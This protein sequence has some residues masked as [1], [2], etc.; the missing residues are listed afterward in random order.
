MRVKFLVLGFLLLF[1]VRKGY[2]QCNVTVDKTDV[3][4]NGGNNGS[5]S[6]NVAGGASNNCV[7]PPTTTYTCASGCTSTITTNTSDV[8]VGSGQQVCITMT[9]FNKG[10]T[11]NGGTLIIC[12][13]ATPSSVTFNGGTMIVNGTA[14]FNS[15]SVSSS[16]AVLTNYGTIN[17]TSSFSIAGTFNNHGVCNITSGNLND[18][19][20]SG[21][22]NNTN[23]ITI[24]SGDLN[25]NGTF[26][27]SG[28]LTIGGAWYHNPSSSMINNCNITA[29]SIQS[30]GTINN[31]GKI[32][33]TNAFALNSNTI[34]TQP[35]S[36]V[37][38]GSFQFNSGSIVAAG[39]NCSSFKVNGNAI[40]NTGISVT[41][42]VSIC[43]TGT[44]QNNSGQTIS[45][46]NCTCN[47]GSSTCTYS[48]SNGATTRSVSNL[49]A[50]TYT[51]NTTCSGCSTV[52]NT[53]TIGQPSA[54]LA[55][56]A[57]QTNVDCNGNPGSI[58]LTV[59][60]GTSPYTYS[61][62]NGSNQVISTQ[63]N[64][65]GLVAGSYTVTITD[66]KNCTKQYTYTITQAGSGLTLSIPTP[67]S[68]CKGGIYGEITL[69]VTGGTAPFK[70]TWK[71][72]LNV[73]VDS[74]Q[75]P[76]NLP[77]GT[78]TV[79]VKDAGTCTYLATTTIPQFSLSIGVS[80]TN[81]N[82]YNGS[83]GAIGLTVTGGTAPYNYIWNNGAET[84]SLSNLTAG[85]YSVVVYDSKMCTDTVN[86]A[87]SSPAQ[88]VTSTISY[89]IDVEHQAIPMY[90]KIRQMCRLQQHKI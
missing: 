81:L 10:I 58:N 87:I 48:W 4:C 53:V 17:A 29:G 25:N 49:T 57:T 46:L 86:V 15:V 61:W 37:I 50:G 70:Y 39:S 51:V 79:S 7:T 56:T 88:L 40:I 45:Q 59:S 84:A 73:V 80:T 82:C 27:N 6:V 28:T 67:A 63:Q 69:N 64:P 71:N 3:S 21:V 42:P 33:I 23:T 31:N 55:A 12:G 8:T 47:I 20:P 44:T 36:Q 34:T 14:T 5:A 13:T 2:S 89:N 62:K 18:Q 83:N 52:V 66:S 76:K 77:A 9:G 19:S 78:Y 30:G 43:V 65:T 16:T 26:V 38:C 68:V 85:N 54:A 24:S 32:T 11:M 35:G 72:A 74:V 60:G 75:N 22:I 90:G 1:C 41:G